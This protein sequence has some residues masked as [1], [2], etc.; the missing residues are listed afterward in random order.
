MLVALASPA[1]GQAPTLAPPFPMGMK[2]GSTVELNLTG[3]N[4]AN[5]TGVLTSFPAKVTI[6]TDGGNGK[7]NA[8]LRVRIESAADAPLGFHTLRVATTKG[9]SNFRLF[10]IDELPELVETANNHSVASAQ[11]I[12][13]PCVIAGRA[14]ATV[15]DYFK[16]KAE[17]GQRLTFEVLGRR[18]GSMFDPQVTLYEADGT[19]LPGGYDND[20]PGRQTDPSLQ[21]SFEKAGEYVV[22]VRDVSYGGGA[23]F[24]YRLRIG[25]FPSATTPMPMAVSPGTK[26]TIGFAG[27]Q[28]A[29]AQPVEVSVPTAPE[30][31]RM[32]IA[33]LGKSGLHGWP[34][35]L[36]I[37]EMPTLVEKEP[38]D[39]ATKA[40]RLAVPSGVSGAF[41]QKGDRDHFLFTAK[42]GE[43][44]QLDV[45][46]HDLHS[47]ADVYMV[48]Q[49][50]KGKQLLA[51]D[52]TKG[53]SL[54]F[55]PPADGDYVIVLEHLHY[56]YGPAQTY[57]LSINSDEPGFS[58][59]LKKDA[60][61]APSGGAAYVPVQVTRRNYTGPIA[62]KAVGLD[63]I[64][65]TLTVEENK[66]SGIL[67][68]SIPAD[69]PPG[70]R[71]FQIVGE[72]KHDK[73]TLR[74]FGSAGSLIQGQLANLPVPPHGLDTQLALAVIEK[75]PF[76][77]TAKL[78]ADTSAPGKPVD[79]VVTAVRQ[80]DFKEA[81][82]L[83]ALEL[84]ANVK[85]VLKPIPAGMNEVKI[86]LQPAANAP[87]GEHIV[88]IEGKAKHAGADH[89]ATAPPLVW[90]LKK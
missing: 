12:A 47:P 8:K 41:L 29:D 32:F 43:K 7:D 18:L 62:L 30:A 46:T 4:L 35:C 90:T 64:S 22:M 11:P 13:V 88:F 16:F 65:R 74:A 21:Y 6:P 14:D 15:S 68:L 63:G 52:P 9:V 77:L 81:I 42:K 17:A 34:V 36:S 58:L 89:A 57:Y 2:A 56:W 75:Q 19:E 60:Y 28:A 78:A 70:P 49:D 26:T 45:A 44:V 85:A 71:A 50:A 53:Q 76:T 55:T 27:P 39:D 61:A 66:T 51:G 84:P 67:A 24:V 1:P 3:A 23:D 86:Q 5:P 79:V 72:A 33:P 20:A 48:V 54:T 82:T 38:N 37:A 87:V 83:A 59:A 31:A 40:T 73:T 10:C 80:A 69:A 25:D